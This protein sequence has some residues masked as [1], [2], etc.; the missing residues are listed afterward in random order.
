MDFGADESLGAFHSAGG[1]ERA[2]T[3]ISAEI[4]KRFARLEELRKKKEAI[5]NTSAKLAE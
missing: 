2:K 4:Q 5:K 3:L 1:M